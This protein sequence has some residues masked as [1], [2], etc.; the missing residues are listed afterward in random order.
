LGWDRWF[1]SLVG[2]PD[3]SADKPD[4]APVDLALQAS[5][6]APGQGVWFVGDTAMDLACAHAAGCVPVLVGPGHGAAEEYAVH[7]PRHRAADLGELARLLI[8]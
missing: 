2:A 3:A 6:I 7:P 4:R 5:G 8:A 1:G